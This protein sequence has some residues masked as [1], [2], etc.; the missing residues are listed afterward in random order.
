MKIYILIVLMLL[1]ISCTTTV[2]PKIADIPEASGIAYCLDSDT[3]VVANDEGW[4][5]E[6]SREGEI[7]SK[8]RAKKY[9]LEGV[10]CEKDNYL[11]AV[12]D[13]GILR[14]DRKSGKMKLIT[15]DEKYQNK[16]LNIFNKKSGIEGIT[17]VGDLY[18]LA[19]QSKKKNES[20]I[21]VV[22]LEKNKSK[23]VD[24]IQHNIVDSA[25]LDYHNGSLYIV[26]DKKDQMIQ[27]DIKQKKIISK[28]KLSKF[29]QEGITFDNKGFV[30]IAD[31]NG[32]VVKYSEDELG[33]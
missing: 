9:D 25:G 26:S 23:I 4:Y 2:S 11:F 28:T 6:I 7:L 8:N 21:V 27:Y 20:Y 16:K 14:V 30:Y 33:V 15:I 1:S 31:D 29:A 32:A 24:I 22:K 3:L 10:V 12:E 17:K 18:Y 19:K 5:Y 13:K